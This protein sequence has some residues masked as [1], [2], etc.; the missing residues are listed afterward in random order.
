G[1]GGGPVAGRAARHRRGGDLRPGAAGPGHAVPAAHRGAPGG[2][3]RGGVR[4]RLRRPA[5]ARAAA[6]AARPARCAD[7]R[8]ARPAGQPPG[9]QAGR[10]GGAHPRRGPA[11]GRHGGGGGRSRTGEL[12]GDQVTYGK[13]VI[14]LSVVET[15]KGSAVNQLRYRFGSSAVLYVG[16]D[17]TD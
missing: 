10:S 3:P 15:N 7:R 2:Q 9:G 1:G 13:E 16:D 12:A 11:G 17:V 4:R 14:E 6:A 8:G 5:R